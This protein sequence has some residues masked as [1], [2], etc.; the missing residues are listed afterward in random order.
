MKKINLIIAAALSFGLLQA[1]NHGPKD[2]TQ[3]ADSTNAAKDTSKTDSASRMTATTPDNDDA[4][5]AVTAAN[6]GMTEVALSKIALQQVTDSKLKDFANMMI[7]DHTKAGDQLAALAK[8]KNITLPMAVNSDS[9]KII[10]DMTKKS[11]SDFDKAYV[12]QMVTDHEG[13]VKLFQDEAKKAVDP[14]IKAFATNTLPTLQGH[15][16]AIKGIKSSMK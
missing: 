15:L 14:D 5:F 7:T 10:D 16:S 12:D 2:S 8:T 1:C 4:K 13:A 6:A 9:Q 11:G 3:T